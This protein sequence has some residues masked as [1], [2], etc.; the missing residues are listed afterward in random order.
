M[1]F[2]NTIFV[3]SYREREPVEVCIISMT[4]KEILK[5]CCIN[6][7]KYNFQFIIRGEIVCMCRLFFTSY[8]ILIFNFFFYKLPFPF[9]SSLSFIILILV[10][11]L[12]CIFFFLI[13]LSLF[14]LFIL[15]NEV[16][17]FKHFSIHY[18]IF[19]WLSYKFANCLWD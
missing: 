18:T 9:F 1:N 3:N 13:N 14:H 12:V 17:M 5:M 11:L 2:S 7:F 8:Y 15:K 10:H 6:M 16:C 4:L 19:C